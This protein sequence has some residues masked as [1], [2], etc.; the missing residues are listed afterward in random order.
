MKAVVVGFVV[1]LF[2]SAGFL[3]G[4]LISYRLPEHHLRSDSKDIVKLGIGLIATMTALVLGLVT[5]S[6]KSS[7]D[8]LNLAVKRSATEILIL[9]RTLARYG[10]ETKGIRE[11]LRT[12]INHRMQVIWSE[13]SRSV[14]RDTIDTTRS[15]ERLEDEIRGLSP[16]NDD[17]RWLKSKAIDVSENLLNARWVLASGAGSSVPRPFV[18]ILIFWLTVTFGSFGLFAPRNATVVGVLLVCAI[19]MACAL[20][21][22]L[23][24]ASPFDGPIKISPDPLRYAASQVGQ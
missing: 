5:A 4:M 1:F 17:Q 18:G 21:L 12:L 11:E 3:T 6:V 7:F 9:D 16:Q 8:E 24:M 13:P 2:S 22:I 23:A 20:F 15:A 14:T 10:P 19:S